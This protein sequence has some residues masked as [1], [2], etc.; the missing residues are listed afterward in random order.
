MSTIASPREPSLSGRRIPL[1]STPTSSSRPSLDTPRSD[2]SPSRPSIPSN[3]STS[4]NTSTAGPTPQPKRN[5]A[6][7]RE[8]YNLQ[9]TAAA[10]SSLS[11]T[12]QAPS[13]PASS[14][15]HSFVD[16]N[17][18]GYGEEGEGSE[19]DKEGFNGEEYVRKV[20][21][22]KSLGEVLAIYRGVLA[23]VRALDAERKALVYDN[24]S[25]L[26]VATEMIGRMREG[27][28]VGDG[29]A[30]A[31]AGTVKVGG[32]GI[33][34][35]SGSMRGT[36]KVEG[37]EGVEELVERVRQGVEALRRDAESNGPS[38]EEIEKAE[39]RRRLRLVAERVLGTPDKVR[40]LVKEGK[41]DEARILWEKEKKLLERWR[42]RGVGGPDVGECIE[43]G[44]RALR[45]EEA[46][47]GKEESNS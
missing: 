11:T 42:E 37:V 34:S 17:G 15:I 44:D 8:Y 23:D 41:V 18:F 26:I 9:K 19:M 47:G 40:G 30:E 22:E 36:G 35:G 16:D 29:A 20:L 27:V 33:G 1:L 14:S 12:S 31:G 4:T 10:S 13:S 21:E 5:R 2:S 24:Y 3:T 39:K 38:R 46:V 28:K 25:K 43:D 7:L 32:I 45:G 6:A